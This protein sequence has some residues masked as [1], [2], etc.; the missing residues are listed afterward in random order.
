MIAG[1]KDCRKN[2]SQFTL[3]LI[4]LVGDH[5]FG[6]YRLLG[7]NVFTDKLVS[8]CWRLLGK[9][10]CKDVD[11]AAPKNLPAIVLVGS[12]DQSRTSL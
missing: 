8:G 1:C 12:R 11:G 3:G 9:S 4:A 10:S 6:N 5:P 7:K 2:S